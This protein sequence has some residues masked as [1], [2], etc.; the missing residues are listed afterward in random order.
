MVEPWDG[1]WALP[2]RSE[3]LRSVL[4]GSRDRGL[5]IGKLRRRGV[6]GKQRGGRVLCSELFGSWLR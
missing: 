3:P 5:G 1:S 6:P 2:V 4:G